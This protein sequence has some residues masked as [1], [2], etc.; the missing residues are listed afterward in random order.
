M[1]TKPALVLNFG[2]ELESTEPQFSFYDNTTSTYSTITLPSGLYFY[3]HPTTAKNIV[4]VLNVL[5]LGSCVISRQNDRQL[6]FT[7]ADTA[8]HIL[9]RQTENDD[10]LKLAEMLGLYDNS[11]NLDYYTQVSMG[12]NKITQVTLCTWFSSAG[13]LQDYRTERGYP[14]GD[15]IYTESQSGKSAGVA[16]GRRRK[17]K[18]LKFTSI[19]ANDIDPADGVET[20]TQ[21]T[22]GTTEVASFTTSFW[23]A[24]NPELHASCFYAELDTWNEAVIKG[25][26]W[27]TGSLDDNCKTRVPGNALLFDL[28]ITA[29]YVPVDEQDKFL[30]FGAGALASAVASNDILKA[31]TGDMSIIIDFYFINNDG[32]GTLVQAWSTT[33]VNIPFALRIDNAT[34]HRLYWWQGTT[35]GSQY[36]GV[37]IAGLTPNTRYRL[38]VTRTGQTGVNNCSIWINGALTQWSTT[39]TPIESDGKIGAMFWPTSSSTT[40]YRVYGYLFELQ[41]FNYVLTAGEVANANLGIKIPP[42]KSIV[43]YGYQERGGQVH[44]DTSGNNILMQSLNTTWQ[45]MP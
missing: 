32:A 8:D 34:T 38:V 4:A 5:L 12:N 19:S 3:N 13:R 6:K 39:K 2:I 7:F 14:R 1:R 31:F 11:G 27:L 15:A 29:C 16:T 45:V 43:N 22:L 9:L 23:R 20:S 28:T 37:N 42:E 36:D 40:N 18:D 25:E 41:L 21:T 26:W 30:Y 33:S 44:L 17:I 35:T 10:Y 24:Y